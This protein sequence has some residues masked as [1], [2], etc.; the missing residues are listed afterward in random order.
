MIIT[1]DKFE[2]P[3][4]CDVIGAQAVAD[5]LGI[6]LQYLRRMLCGAAPWSRKHK[7]KAVSLG[8]YSEQDED[9]I[10]AEI[11]PLSEDERRKIREK[12]R[13]ERHI[14]SL[15]HTREYNRIYY[16][17]NREQI[18]QRMKHNYRIRKEE[19]EIDVDGRDGEKQSE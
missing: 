17:K 6:S 2:T 5:Y 11:Q 14:A 18:I 16:Q 1:N 4:K 15:K 12:R 13:E 10:P 19:R 7:Y 3:V 9:I 8:W